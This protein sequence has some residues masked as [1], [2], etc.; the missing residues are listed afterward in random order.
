MSISIVII[1]N[2]SERYYNTDSVLYHLLFLRRQ[3]ATVA[4]F[5]AL[6]IFM[7]CRLRPIALILVFYYNRNIRTKEVKR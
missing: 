7:I 2:N 3:P 6:K 1:Y 5:V 4:A